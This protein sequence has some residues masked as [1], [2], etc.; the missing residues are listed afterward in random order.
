MDA[1]LSMSL[2]GAWR[3]SRG[4]QMGMA[5]PEPGPPPTVGSVVALYAEVGW[6]EPV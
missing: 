4:L 5:A 2:S 1:S 6:M 3:L